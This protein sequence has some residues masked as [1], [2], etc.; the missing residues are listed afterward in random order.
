MKSNQKRSIVLLV[1]AAAML[2]AG[3]RGEAGDLAGSASGR[4]TTPAA[5]PTLP[6]LPTRAPG[7]VPATVTPALAPEP[8][9][10][11]TTPTPPPPT[12]PPT[13][14]PSNPLLLPGVYVT[15]ASVALASAPGGPGIA[16]APAGTRLGLLGRSEDAAWVHVLYQPDSAQPPVSG[17]VRA[18]AVT[19][20]TDLADLAP[21][22]QIGAPSAI[23]IPAAAGSTTAAVLANRL[24]LRAGP[25]AGERVLGVLIQGEQ[26]QVLG[27]SDDG[28]WWQVQ[29]ADGD[30]GWAAARYLQPG[31][32]VGA[33]MAVRLPSTA[34]WG[35][36]VVQER[37]GGDIYISDGDGS[38]LRRLSRGLDPALSPDGRQVAFARWDEPRGLWLI[39]SDG[40]GERLVFGANR[41]RSPAWSA[42]GGSIVFEQSAGSK[43]C[44]QS[45]FG[46]LSDDELRQVLGGECR[47]TPF[48]R[49]C[50][51]D[52]PLSNLEFTTLVRLDLATGSARNL[53]ASDSA[54]AP[55]M[56]PGSQSVVYGD[57]EGLA[58]TQT[59]GDAPPVRI[60]ADARPHGAVSFSPDGRYLFGSRRDGDSWNIWRWTADG[61]QATALTQPPALRSAPVDN[62]APT[63]SAD[64]RTILFLSNRRGR[65]ELW[66]MG[67]DG[68]NQQLFAPS[69][70]SGLNFEYDFNHERVADWGS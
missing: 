47:E 26:V 44:R 61:G 36:I 29:T 46:C 19:A 14:D 1:L 2:L 6:V 38:A 33:A 21:V 13:P 67:P 27:R 40:S 37:S 3:C 52:F 17:W 66:Q 24:N 42:D 51:G 35:R 70:L 60:L 65:W 64:G 8:G 4:A 63:V 7:L 10:P 15:A 48:G 45:P 23:A 57:K 50:I 20:F 31:G 12:P 53:P 16:S 34:G 49:F 56:R 28:V 59:T 62:V 54:R 25:G 18:A 69:A 22:E 41:A 68:E 32:R 5:F 55:T 58:A 43:V 39:N 11:P 9:P 30:R